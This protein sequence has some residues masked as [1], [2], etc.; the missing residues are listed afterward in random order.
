MSPKLHKLRI[1]KFIYI[2]IALEFFSITFANSSCDLKGLMTLYLGLDWG[3]L[4][5]YAYFM[6]MEL[7]AANYVD[8]SS[9]YRTLFTWFVLVFLVFLILLYKFKQPYCGLLLL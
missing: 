9:L 6:R 3:V 4:V 5:I 2:I 1:P 7:P 8:T